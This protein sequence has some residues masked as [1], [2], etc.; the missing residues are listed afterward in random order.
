MWAVHVYI[1][2]TVFKNA[3]G[4]LDFQR[5][6]GKFLTV[7]GKKRAPYRPDVIFTDAEDKMLL[8]IE[9]HV[10]QEIDY[11]KLVALRRA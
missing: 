4:G 1:E 8:L 7:P 10:T 2:R 9:I 3:A 5:E 11:K 6:A